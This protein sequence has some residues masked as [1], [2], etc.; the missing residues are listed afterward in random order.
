[1]PSTARRLVSPILATKAR[2]FVMLPVGSII[3]AP[4]SLEE[5][6][7]RSVRFGDE[8]IFT[9]T[10]D[11]QERTEPVSAAPEYEPPVA[12]NPRAGPTQAE[13]SHLAG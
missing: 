9:F 7:L 12:R 1:M 11:I 8:E 13:R 2:G 10:R 3:E 6:G 4:D 5:P